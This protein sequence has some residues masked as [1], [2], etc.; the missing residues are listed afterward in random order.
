[1]EQ[2]IKEYLPYVYAYRSRFF[3]SCEATL[4]MFL[5]AGGISFVLGLL[6]G[7]VLCMAV[8]TATIGPVSFLGLIVANLA[9][10]VLKTYKHSHLIAG[11]SL[12]GMLALIGGQ[13]ISQHV[14]H[15]TV[16]V[17]TFVTSAGGIYFLWLLLSRKGAY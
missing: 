17:S 14:F 2:L 5:I 13:L 10:Q 11:A 12:M 8:A 15:F 7:V 3:Q 16:P 6:F 4:H 1:M 9:R